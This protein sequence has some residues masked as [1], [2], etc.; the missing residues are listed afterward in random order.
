MLGLGRVG[1]RLGS[2]GLRALSTGGS[3]GGAAFKVSAGNPKLDPKIKYTKVEATWRQLC[4]FEL[5]ANGGF[6]QLGGGFLAKKDYERVCSEFRLTNGQLWPIPIVFDISEAIKAE[7][8]AGDG[9]LLIRTDE[10]LYC[11]W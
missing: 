1:K 4:D 9:K 3:G 10:H 2:A 11:F 5:I 6:A 8:E 7:L